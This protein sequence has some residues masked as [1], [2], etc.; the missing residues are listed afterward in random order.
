MLNRL[1]M[2][3][4]QHKR[5]HLFES[6]V[7]C[8]EIDN[9]NAVVNLAVPLMIVLDEG[10][11]PWPQILLVYFFIW[12]YW[13]HRVVLSHFLVDSFDEVCCTLSEIIQTLNHFVA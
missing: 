10:V 6:I 13:I 5:L 7:R 11:D 8:E 12:D 1:L 4:L 9:G 2:S 3:L